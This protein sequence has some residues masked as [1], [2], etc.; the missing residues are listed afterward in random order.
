MVILKFTLAIRPSVRHPYFKARVA[1][2]KIRFDEQ[3][4]PIV[5]EIPDAVLKNRKPTTR[6]VIP[7]PTITAQA[8]LAA[9]KEGK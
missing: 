6:V 2:R 8:M 5:M 4:F 3:A 9:A 1:G 7:I